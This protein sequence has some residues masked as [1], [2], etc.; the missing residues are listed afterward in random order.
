MD[1]RKGPPYLLLDARDREAVP[2]RDLR[3]AKALHM[4]RHEN[5]P[6]L[7]FQGVYSS[8]KAGKT[9]ARLEPAKL[10]DAGKVMIIG[11]HMRISSMPPRRFRAIIQ[12]DTRYLT[13]I[14]GRP[15]D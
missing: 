7:W 1:L 12:E 11:I 5:L 6:S 8:F 13:E 9:I 15:Q 4:V 14:D 3:M 2:R 10:V